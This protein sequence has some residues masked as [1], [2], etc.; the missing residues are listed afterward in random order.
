MC[1]RDRA[2]KGDAPRTAHF[3]CV[4]ALVWPD[5]HLESFTGRI[6]GTLVWPPRGDRG[7]GYDPIFVPDGENMT[8]G[9]MS[10]DAKHAMSHRAHAFRQLVEACLAP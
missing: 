3:I 9:E 6:D 2:A 8:F 1:I 5:G 10:P 4:L 7:F